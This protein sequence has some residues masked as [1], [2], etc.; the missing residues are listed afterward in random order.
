LSIEEN[1]EAGLNPLSGK[2]G[3]ILEE[4]VLIYYSN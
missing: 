2:A 3:D 4:A 1:V